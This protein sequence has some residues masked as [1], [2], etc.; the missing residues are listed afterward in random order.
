MARNKPRTPVNPNPIILSGDSDSEVERY[1]ASEYPYSEGLCAKPSY[2]FVKN[3][4]PCLQSDP[5][6]PGIKLPY[7][8]PGD[9]SKPSPALPQ[10]AVPPCD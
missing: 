6:Y 7:E 3:L 9:S 4:P 10:P 8:T 2:N 5:N 1:L